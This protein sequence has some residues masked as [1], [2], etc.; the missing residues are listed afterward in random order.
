MSLLPDSIA[1]TRFSALDALSQR[2]DAVDISVLLVY[3]IDLV[4]ASALPV[5][6]WQL[7]VE[8]YDQNDSLAVQRQKIR[9]SIVLHRRY[10]TPWAIRRALELAGYTHVRVIEAIRQYNNY[11]GYIDFDGQYIFDGGASNWATYSVAFGAQA[12]LSPAEFAR[13]RRL[14]EGV[15]PAR[16]HLVNIIQYDFLYDGAKTYAGAETFDGQL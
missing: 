13:I 14:L 15:Q 10:G 1:D 9:A 2:L 11:D 16:C 3:L 12:I 6:A 4:P 7:H 5:L 8:Q